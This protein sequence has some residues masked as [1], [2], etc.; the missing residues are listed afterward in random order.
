MNRRLLLA[1]IVAVAATQLLLWWL[2][3]EPKPR[4]V[5]GPPRSGYSLEHFS[6][7]VLTRSG[8]IGFTLKAPQ[9]QRRDADDSLFIDD[10][11]FAM[12]ASDGS[13][14]QGQA[15]NGWVN[16]DGSI[17][18]LS[19]HVLMQRPATASLRQASIR[20]ADL[21]AWPGE[22]RMRTEA[23][24]E[25]REPGRI[26]SGTGM[27]VDFAQHTMELLA[28]VHGTFEPHTRR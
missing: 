22:K 17:L 1:L 2:R 19:G 6:L 18:K 26:L 13:Q 9:L 23:R 5:A 28:D 25:I 12:P 3:P 27:K 7:D 8:A 20:T 15:E 11:R 4:Q 16:A 21:T 10:P 14:W 24:A